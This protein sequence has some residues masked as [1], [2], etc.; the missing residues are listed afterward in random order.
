MEAIKIVIYNTEKF[1]KRKTSKQAV[2]LGH[3]SG[4]L[5]VFQECHSAS[6]MDH[7]LT[8]TIALESNY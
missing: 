6:A 8:F 1:S 4:L 2:F 5:I 7:D 3:E